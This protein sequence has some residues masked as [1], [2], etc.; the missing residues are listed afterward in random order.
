MDFLSNY[1][2]LSLEERTKHVDLTSPCDTTTRGRKFRAKFELLRRF[3]LVNDVWDWSK[4]AVHLCHHCE[5]D[6]SN[7]WC[8]NPLHLHVGTCKENYHMRPE[9]QR[10]KHN[11]N[12]ADSRAKKGYKTVTEALSGTV[13][14]TDENGNS[15]R[16]PV[17]EAQQ[18]GLSMT[19]SKAVRL[20]DETTG[21]LHFFNNVTACA[22]FLGVH[23]PAVTRAI[24]QDRCLLKHFRPTL[25]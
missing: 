23:T 18:R 8:G 1:L 24:K 5:N 6:S 25:Q 11:K 13:C 2:K 15:V 17:V 12:A 14:A 4:S 9:E 22:H 20:L 16:V 19:T 10:Y 7:G 3:E 21:E